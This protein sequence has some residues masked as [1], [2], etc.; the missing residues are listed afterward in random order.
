ML[1]EPRTGHG[2]LP[3]TAAP[4]HP[5]MNRC[6]MVQRGVMKWRLPL[7]ACASNTARENPRLENCSTA[8]SARSRFPE[9]SCNPLVQRGELLARTNARDALRNREH[10]TGPSAKTF[11][12]PAIIAAGIGVKAWE[13]K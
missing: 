8:P 5:T 12:S 10:P 1:L 9:V 7:S 3:T 4:S 2:A 11:R 13:R 6:F